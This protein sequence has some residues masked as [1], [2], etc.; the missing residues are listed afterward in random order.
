M[1]KI[2]SVVINTGG[3]AVT[4]GDGA[5]VGSIVE[6]TALVGEALGGPS[7]GPVAVEPFDLFISY[8]HVDR[9]AVERIAAA[10]ESLGLSV[11]YDRGLTTGDQF[12]HEI[13]GRLAAARRVLVVW[14]PAALASEWVLNEAEV[15]RRSGKLLAASLTPMA[16]PAPFALTHAPLLPSEPAADD[17]VLADIFA[18]ARGGCR[19][20]PAGDGAVASGD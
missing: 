4:I 13:N 19:Y 9:A 3:G 12:L 2:N 7:G 18:A 16:L 17:P 10:L 20:H 5:M 6:Q 1:T 15:A 14:S 11:W 8:A